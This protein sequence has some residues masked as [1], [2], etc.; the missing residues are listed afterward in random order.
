MQSRPMRKK[1]NILQCRYCYTEK[2][3]DRWTHYKTCKKMPGETYV[4]CEKELVEEE[5][6]A[7]SMWKAFIERRLEPNYILRCYRNLVCE[8]CDIGN[9]DIFHVMKCA[10]APLCMKEVVKKIYYHKD[11]L[12]RFLVVSN[13]E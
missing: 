3:E 1:G 8:Y 12:P 9:T 5:E 7:H 13:H 10:C 6:L 2:F 4:R 11:R